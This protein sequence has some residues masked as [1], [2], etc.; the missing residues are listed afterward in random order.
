MSDVA[1]WPAAWDALRA[2]DGVD[3]DQ[4]SERLD[5]LWKCEY[6]LPSSPLP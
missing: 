6:P 5:A 2:L 4:E 3:W 1:D